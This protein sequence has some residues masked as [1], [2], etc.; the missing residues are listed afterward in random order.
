[1]KC[2]GDF[3]LKKSGRRGSEDDELEV[4]GFYTGHVEVNRDKPADN[5]ERYLKTGWHLLLVGVAVVEWRTAETKLRKNLLAGCA[6]WHLSCAV[7]D[8]LAG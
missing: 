8:W 4:I 6:G 2:G 5:L 1:M 7:V 3:L